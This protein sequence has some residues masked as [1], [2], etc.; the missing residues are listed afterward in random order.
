MKKSLQYAH[1]FLKIFHT[2]SNPQNADL[3]QVEHNQMNHRPFKNKQREPFCA[4]VLKGSL[5]L[6]IELRFL[7]QEGIIAARANKLDHTRKRAPYLAHQLFTF[8]TADLLPNV[9]A[10]DFH[11]LTSE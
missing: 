8:G 11:A 4:L 1:Q 3:L 5:A 7:Y 2:S 9:L 6:R 10:V